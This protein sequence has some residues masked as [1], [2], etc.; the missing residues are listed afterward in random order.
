MPQGYEDVNTYDEMKARGKRLGV[1]GVAEHMALDDGIQR[2]VNIQ[3]WCL[4]PWVRDLPWKTYRPVYFE[5]PAQLKCATCD[6]VRTKSSKIWWR[7]VAEN[8]GAG[9]STETHICH[10][11]YTSP[12]WTETMPEGYEDVRRYRDLLARNTQIRG[13]DSAGKH[14]RHNRDR[15]IALED[16]P[17]SMFQRYGTVQMLK[18][19][20]GKISKLEDVV[21]VAG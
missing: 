12:D 21:E 15:A 7:K 8:Q 6:F 10:N 9:Q 11:C 1:T 19:Q 5:N 17:A 3:S 4:R 16:L 14:M 2:R 13:P 18:V 20:P